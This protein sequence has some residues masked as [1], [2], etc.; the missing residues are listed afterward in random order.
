MVYRNSCFV[1]NIHKKHFS[2][3]Y[4]PLA[5][6]EFHAVD[7]RCGKQSDLRP[8]GT[9]PE[10]KFADFFLIFFECFCLF[11]YVCLSPSNFDIYSLSLMQLI[12]IFDIDTFRGVWGKCFSLRGGVGA[13][14]ILL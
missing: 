10:K 14:H 12:W 5:P 4:V 7:E 6:D 8:Q 11:V 1:L 9:K 13:M 2:Y 3:K